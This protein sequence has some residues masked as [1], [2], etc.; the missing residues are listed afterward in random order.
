[1]LKYSDCAILLAAEEIEKGQG[2]YTWNKET[3][4]KEVRKAVW[5][6]ISY[7]TD[8]APALPLGDPLMHRVTKEK[9]NP[10]QELACTPGRGCA[11]RGR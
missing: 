2:S 4:L 7:L 9:S 1:M 8:P 11:L 5:S 3:P 10:G 6:S